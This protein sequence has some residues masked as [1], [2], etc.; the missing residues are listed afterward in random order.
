[1]HHELPDCLCEVEFSRIRKVAIEKGIEVGG[2]IVDALELREEY[3]Q[4]SAEFWKMWNEWNEWNEA[5]SE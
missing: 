4:E 3:R 5:D 2:T 1:M